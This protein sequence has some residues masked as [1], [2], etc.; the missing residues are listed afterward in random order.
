MI[1]PFVDADRLDLVFTGQVGG[2]DLGLALG[3]KE[4]EGKEVTRNVDLLTED[5][6]TFLQT[7]RRVYK[8]G[9][10][11]KIRLLTVHGTEVLVVTGEV[12]R[13]KEGRK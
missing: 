6:T 2:V 1:V 11:V 10:K 4:E 9:Q 8:P 13:G 5:D 7:D 12:R 3:E